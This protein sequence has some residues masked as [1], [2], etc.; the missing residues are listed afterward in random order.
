MRTVLITILAGI[1]MIGTVAA[2]EQQADRSMIG[3][4][5]YHS[6]TTQIQLP[7]P[8]SQRVLQP[9]DRGHAFLPEEAW[10]RVTPREPAAVRIERFHDEHNTA[11]VFAE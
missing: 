7:Q 5:S 9:A 8:T 4:Q 10:V 11:P 6:E 1:G 2:A 3:Q